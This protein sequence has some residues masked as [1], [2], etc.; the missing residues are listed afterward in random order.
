[1]ETITPAKQDLPLTFQAESVQ[2]IMRCVAAGDS[3]AVIGIGSVGKSNL[4]R[5]LLR[6]DVRQTYLGGEGATYL[7]VYVDGN[8]LLKPT[9]GGLVELVLH[10]IGLALA[11]RGVEPSVVQAIDDLHQKSADRK[12]RSLALRYLDRALS[13]VI[14][15]LG[16]RLVL[17]LDEFDELARTMPPRG[18]AALRA[19]RD[20][21]KYRLMYVVATRLELNRL[22]ENMAEIEMFD[23]LVSPQTFWLGLYSEEDAR[24]N[25]SRLMAR[26]K[27]NLPAE[28]IDQLLSL[29]GRHPGLLRE[30]YRVV[31]E[32]PP[33]LGQAL[34][35]NPQIQAECQR[36]W[37]SLA[38]DEQQALVTLA[39]G[40]AFQPQ[41]AGA[42]TRL[43]RKGLVS[44]RG[45]SEASFFSPLFSAYLKQQQPVAG[46][47][48]YIDPQRRTL[49][50]DGREV[51]GFTPLEYRLVAYLAQK[52]G[53]I[54][55]RDELAEHLYP[56][57]MAPDGIGVADTR[58]DSLVKRVRKRIEPDLQEPRY[59]LTARGHGFQ[60][61][62]NLGEQS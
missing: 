25:L 4:L 36:I 48:I 29:T 31:R 43:R 19:L 11:Q 60:L 30:A 37:L 38:A 6:D 7:F 27:F 21:Y 61:L 44:G 8:K 59:L 47:R 20:D 51:K 28:V 55:S 24:W 26:H 56:E 9:L 3:C 40:V 50:L 1:M 54:C 33:D 18:F 5:F 45:E 58:L 49:W 39:A 52:Q 23:E 13:V 14:Q 41:Q 10:Q 42:L 34:A 17:L 12:T 46:V 53:Q 57:E 35:G 2:S 22:R 62:A 16:L 32:Q 15:Q